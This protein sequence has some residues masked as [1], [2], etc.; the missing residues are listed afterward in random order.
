MRRTH[1]IDEYAVF[2]GLIQGGLIL[3]R[4][5]GAIWLADPTTARA[6]VALQRLPD[7][8]AV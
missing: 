5:T 7:S 6:A 2:W 3:C 1:L 4:T 8:D